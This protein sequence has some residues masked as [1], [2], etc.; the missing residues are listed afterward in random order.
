VAPGEDGGHEVFDDFLL[1][2]DLAPDLRQQRLARDTELLEE[3]EV[4]LSGGLVWSGSQNP[5]KVA[6]R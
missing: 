4:A 6:G 3:F 2:D 1:P 5:E